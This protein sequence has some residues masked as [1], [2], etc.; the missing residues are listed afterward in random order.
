MD[1]IV[2]KIAT[3]IADDEFINQFTSLL[4]QIYVIDSADR[5]R[6]EETG[7]ELEELLLEEKLERVPLLVYANKQDLLTAAPASEIAQG[8]GLHNLRDRIWQIQACSAIKSEGIKV[9]GAKREQ[10][11]DFNIF[12]MSTNV[13]PIT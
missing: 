7:Q 2:E 9:M 13:T 6:F 8:L 11:T 12:V 5:K 3:K 10:F 1:Q 4:F